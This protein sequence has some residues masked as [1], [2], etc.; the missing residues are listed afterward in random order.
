[1]AWT[2]VCS[3]SQTTFARAGFC[4]C[5]I[6]TELRDG[7]VYILL[8]LQIFDLLILWHFCCQNFLRLSFT[9][10]RLYIRVIVWLLSLFL[11]AAKSFGIDTLCVKFA[12]VLGC[13]HLS[14]QPSV[15]G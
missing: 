15:K 9:Y 12:L 10:V 14:A 13:V 1:M 5:V 4:K 3:S 6:C 7:T 11:S 8:C 2:G